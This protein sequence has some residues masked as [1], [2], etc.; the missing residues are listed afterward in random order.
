MEPVYRLTY[1]PAFLAICG[2]GNDVRGRPAR[3]CEGV[4][5]GAKGCEGVR[6]AAQ[7]RNEAAHTPTIKSRH[8]VPVAAMP[9][10]AHG[11]VKGVYLPAYGV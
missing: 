3:R 6:G 9:G 7:R 1:C 5:G 8:A 10:G 2:I 4:R 11:V